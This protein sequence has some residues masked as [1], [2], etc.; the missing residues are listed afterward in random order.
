M[1]FDRFDQARQGVQCAIHVC[2]G[3]PSEAASCSDLFSTASYS[4]NSGG[5][6]SIR[7]FFLLTSSIAQNFPGS[8][9]VTDMR[10]PIQ[11]FHAKNQ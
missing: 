8:P 10:R 6:A 11:A 9:Q 1:C 4:R 3:Q 7:T 5:A 2:R